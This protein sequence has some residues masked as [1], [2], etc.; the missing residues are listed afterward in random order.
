MNI[1]PFVSGL[2]GCF[3][4]VVYVGSWS[5][6]VVELGTLSFHLIEI[7]GGLLKWAN[8]PDFTPVVVE[9]AN[10]VPVLEVP[11]KT[12]E[13][14]DTS[15]E[16]PTPA[17]V[18]P[19]VD[20]FQLNAGQQKAFDKIRDYFTNS[21]VPNLVLGGYSGTGKSFL[22][23]KLCTS[24]EA[25]NFYFT[26]P[27]NK[28]TKVLGRMLKPYGATCKTIYSLLGLRM[29]AVE[30]EIQLT[31]PTIETTLDAHIVVDEA[32]MLNKEVKSYLEYRASTSGVKVLYVGDPAQLNPIG[33][34][35][36]PIWTMPNQI[37]LTEVVRYDNQILN[38]A[39]HLREQVFAGAPKLR[40]ESDNNGHEGVWTKDHAGFLNLIDRLSSQGTFSDV[41]SVK[42]IAWRNKVVGKLNDRIR[43][44]I[45]DAEDLSRSKYLIGDRVMIASP[46]IGD[47]GV[48]VWPLV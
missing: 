38:L 14:V 4:L 33:E 18:E 40:L 5:V 10:P 15:F 31:Y 20:D 7:N 42:A 32:G 24:L 16:D 3:S 1:E 36:S 48:S 13:V 28:A 29:E 22:M 23:K 44:N 43:Y 2:I 12:V 46:V 17:V 25:S 30:D 41:D 27:T 34:E 26:A 9:G 45:F 11:P 8:F 35:T 21:S 47:S 39:T 6:D 19:I 37:L